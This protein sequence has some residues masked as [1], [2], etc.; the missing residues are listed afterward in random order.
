VGIGAMLVDTV[1][2]QAELIVAELKDGITL[3]MD[4]DNVMV[5]LNAV[6]D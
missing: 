2:P 4:E 5:E 1:A 3:V 6:E